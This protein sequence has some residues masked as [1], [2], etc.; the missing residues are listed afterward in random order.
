MWVTEGIGYSGGFAP[1]AC[2]G[3]RVEEVV[4]IQAPF[5]GPL[6]IKPPA[7]REDSYRVCVRTRSGRESTESRF[8]C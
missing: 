5:A 8:V 4:A 2:N 7:L 6:I 3:M 1:P